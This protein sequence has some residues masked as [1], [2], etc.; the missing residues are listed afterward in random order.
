MG[1]KQEQHEKMLGDRVGRSPPT[2]DHEATERETVR[3]RKLKLDES[4]D[5]KDAV[6]EATGEPVVGSG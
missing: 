3:E 4:L 2:P 5:I 1:R 6:K